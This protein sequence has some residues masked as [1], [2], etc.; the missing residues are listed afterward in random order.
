MENPDGITNTL[1]YLTNLTEPQY[2]Q[3][4]LSLYATLTDGTTV[5][6]PEFSVST[7]G[8]N[9]SNEAYVFRPCSTYYNYTY[10]TPNKTVNFT[11]VTTAFFGATFSSFY[12]SALVIIGDCMAPVEILTVASDSNGHRKS[13]PK[14]SLHCANI[15]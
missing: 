15:Q 7:N 10:N 4:T 13:L 14:T 2:Q 6:I 9:C 8:V 3:A 1:R 5:N 11:T 12:A